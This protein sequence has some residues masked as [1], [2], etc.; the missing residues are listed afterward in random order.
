MSVIGLLLTTGIANLLRWGA[1][2]LLDRIAATAILP[3]TLAHV[4]A[5]G[6]TAIYS[7]FAHKYIS[8]R[9]AGETP[10]QVTPAHFEAR[11]EQ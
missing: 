11:T 5:V 9:R 6:I 7:F 2:A 8:F 1:P 10:L 4:L 3:E